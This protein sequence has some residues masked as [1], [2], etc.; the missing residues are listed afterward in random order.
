MVEDFSADVDVGS[1]NAF[2]EAMITLEENL[3]GKAMM[4]DKSLNDL[5]QVFVAS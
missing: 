5:Q 4:N 3:F 2:T 1:F